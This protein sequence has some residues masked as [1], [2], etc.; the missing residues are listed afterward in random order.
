RVRGRGG[1]GD[2]ADERVSLAQAATREGVRRRAPRLPNVAAASPLREAGLGRAASRDAVLH[3]RGAVRGDRAGHAQGAM[4]PDPWRDGVVAVVG[5]GRSG[6]A[7]A[8]L[9]AREGARVYASDASDHPDAAAIAQLRDLPGVEVE[10][11]RHD[12]DKIRAAVAVVL[13]PGV[14]PDAPPVGAARAAGV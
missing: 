5:L 12:L 2:A 3:P 9:L 14:P 7:A 6:V 11:G 10:V 13:S 8:R 4:I 1:V